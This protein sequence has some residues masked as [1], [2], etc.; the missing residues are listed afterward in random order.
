V[1]EEAAAAGDVAGA[2]APGAAV[3]RR[4]GVPE[5]V[6]ERR[7]PADSG[8]GVEAEFA[9][10]ERPAEP[11]VAGEAVDKCGADAVVADL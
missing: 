6:V 10:A 7:P 3:A 4:E 5:A 2:G 1:V 9:A 8:Q 11:A